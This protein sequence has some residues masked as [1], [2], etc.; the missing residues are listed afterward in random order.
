MHGDLPSDVKLS[1]LKLPE[2]ASQW[3]LVFDFLKLRREVFIARMRWQLADID[4]IE[5]EQY[6]IAG[7]ATYI[8]AH[9][10]EKVVG[11]ARLIRC[12]TQIDAKGYYSYMIRDAYRGTITLPSALCN[13]EPPTDNKSWELTRLV[14]SHSDPVVAKAILDCANDFIAMNG[15]NRCLFLGPP[16]FLRMAKSYGYAPKKMG[17]IC[18]DESGKFLAFACDVIDRG[19]SY[20]RENK[21]HAEA[22]YPHR[23]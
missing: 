15:G 8:I 17:P 3:D 4:G 7:V 6:D 1:I 2:S 23:D 22:K 10:D 5:F 12:D 9:T 21:V 18:G 11:G 13:D 19:H 14:S 16:A 20:F